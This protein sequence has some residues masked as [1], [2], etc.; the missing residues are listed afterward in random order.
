M[1]VIP[2]LI[3]L[4]LVGMNQVIFRDLT[5]VYGGTI[6]GA[7]LTV[8]LVSIYKSEETSAW[9]GFFC[10]LVAFAD[11][12]GIIGWYALATAA[13][14]VA[15]YHIRNRLNLD[16]LYTRIL[17]VLGGVFVYNLAV[18]VIGGGYGFLHRLWANALPTA[19]YTSIVA[20]VF[21]LFKD[22]RITFRKLRSIF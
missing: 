21:F 14:G 9:Y 19:V 18:L 8:L 2:Y 6:D 1:R 7:A 12:T 11:F 10:G 5:S 3:Y 15:G 22:G 4:L 17:L 13:L 20:T 16:S